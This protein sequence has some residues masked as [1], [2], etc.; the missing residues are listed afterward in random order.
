MGLSKITQ[1]GKWQTFLIPLLLILMLLLTLLLLTR[2][3][4]LRW[5]EALQSTRFHWLCALIGVGVWLM[6]PKSLTP[7]SNLEPG[8]PLSE[9]GL[10][11]SGIDV[12]GCSSGPER[13]GG[14]MGIG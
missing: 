10:L 11:P 13:A 14:G 9:R 2:E 6:M 4:P 1:G 12:P 5:K 7:P 8:S 3:K